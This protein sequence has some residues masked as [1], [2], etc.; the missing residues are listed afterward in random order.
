LDVVSESRNALEL[1]CQLT[2]YRR[3]TLRYTD[4]DDPEEQ[5]LRLKVK[6]KLV[7]SAGEVLQK[8]NIV[9]QASFFLTGPNSKSEVAAQNDLIEDT[10]RRITEAVVEAW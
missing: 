6:M 1:E 9:G 7:N 10:A 3:Q 4:S 2:E 5:R 8:N